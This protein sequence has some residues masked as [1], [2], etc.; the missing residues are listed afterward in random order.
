M[1]DQAW[2]KLLEEHNAIV[3]MA[4]G[5]YE[6]LEV[7]TLGDGFL[8]AFLGPRRALRCARQIQLEVQRLG[9]EV[10]AGMHTGE[11]EIQD[12]DLAGI[13]VHLAARIAALA[14][15]GELLVSAT[16]K[17]LVLGSDFAF[18]DRGITDLKGLPGRWQ[19]FE[20]LRE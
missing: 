14:A 19:I 18:K 15:G 7:K 8:A 4:I 1:G 2:S 5:K 6:G 9:I 17:D 10:R 12:D 16:V 13:A 3:R 11:C 20:V